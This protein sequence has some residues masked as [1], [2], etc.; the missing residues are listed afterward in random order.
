MF[1]RDSKLDTNLKSVSNIYLLQCNQVRCVTIALDR[2]SGFSAANYCEAS[3]R[4]GEVYYK[5]S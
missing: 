4:C 1:I 5:A 3:T 2:C